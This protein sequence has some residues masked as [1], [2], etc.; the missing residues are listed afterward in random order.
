MTPEPTT[1]YVRE[2]LALQGCEVSPE[3][4]QAIA[5]ALGAQLATA[6]PAY[7]QLAFE[8]EPAAYAALMAREAR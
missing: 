6:A 2:V 5:A 4:A 7:A 1:D 8:A 3:I